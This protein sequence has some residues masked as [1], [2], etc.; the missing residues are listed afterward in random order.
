[1]ERAG[2]KGSTVPPPGFVL[3]TDLTA[4]PSPPAAP[5]RP[6]PN[7]PAPGKRPRSSMAPTIV[8]QDGR[9]LLAVGSPGG[10]TIITTV[11]AVLTNR[12]DRGQALV[13]AISAPRQSQRNTASIQAEPA[14]PVGGRAGL[15]ALGHTFTS[16]AEIG[17]A[18]AVEFLADG[19]VQAAAET[20]RRGGGSAMVAST[21]PVGA[22]KRSR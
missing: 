14:F 4:S 10:A 19:R 5:P 7:L 3:N 11:L 17:A 9:P 13:D 16:T 18:T 20:T 22:A 15:Q 8:L 2:G 1:M 12:L 6:E 21:T